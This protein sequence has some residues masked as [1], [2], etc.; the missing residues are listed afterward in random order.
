LALLPAAALNFR[1]DR[2][3]VFLGQVFL[4]VALCL[5]VLA[6]S[7]IDR[8]GHRVV[9]GSLMDWR[10]VPACLLEGVALLMFAALALSLSTRLNMA[11]TVAILTALLFA[12]LLSDYLASRLPSYPALRFGLSALLPDLQSFWPADELSGGGTVTAAALG[13]A[14][15]Y[16][17]CYATGVLCLGLAAFRHRQF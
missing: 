17:C 7:G 16:A 11:P 14:I 9:F 10:L 12:G 15:L 4:I 6:M 5:A 3:F 1:Q 13:R 8:T 2:S